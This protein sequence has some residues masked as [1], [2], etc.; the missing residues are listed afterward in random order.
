MQD[1]D[2]DFMDDDVAD[3]FLKKA[4]EA[5]NRVFEK[6]TIQ[7]I[8]TDKL[9]RGTTGGEAVNW[10]D[11]MPALPGTTVNPAT[12]AEQNSS[13]SAAIGAERGVKHR[14]SGP[15]GAASAHFPI[16]P[17]SVTNNQSSSR[18]E[19]G[20]RGPNSGSEDQDSSAISKNTI[21]GSIGRPEA[22]GGSV[23]DMIPDYR[24]PT[25]SVASARR[26]TK[27][28]PS[29]RR[30]SKPGSRGGSGRNSIY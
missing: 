19:I 26:A 4:A 3:R 14:I 17:T 29:S 28:K 9:S 27:R 5:S 22:H 15:A 25:G 2:V 20:G 18:K 10:V 1:D 21:V 6:K 11:L 13:E 16:P 24:R 23:K 7:P 30:Q 8:H 12:S